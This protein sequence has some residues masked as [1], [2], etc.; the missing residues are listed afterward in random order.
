VTT[1]VAFRNVDDEL[2]LELDGDVV[3]RRPYRTRGVDAEFDP[4]GRTRFET[5]VAIEAQGSFSLTDVGLWRDIFYLPDGNARSGASSAV[6][7][8]PDH[9]YMV[10]GDNTQNSWDTRQWEMATYKLKDGREIS[11]NY[12]AHGQNPLANP[13][14]NPAVDGATIWFR[15]I[16][17]QQ[18]Q[19]PRTDLA[20]DLD[21]PTIVSVHS[22]PADFL[23]GKALAV[24]WPLPPFS[25]TWR[26]KWVR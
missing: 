11:G 7:V 12:F 2:V 22:F 18:Y 26:L 4:R 3:L 20:G 21:D 25:P 17:G 15:N 9:E 14:S 23:L 8:V 16:Y 24:F 10:L 19:F 13:D 5:H 1:R 6:Y